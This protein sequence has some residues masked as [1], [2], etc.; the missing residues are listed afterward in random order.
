MANKYVTPAGAGAKD[1][2]SWDNAF[3]ATEFF[4]DIQSGGTLTAGDI[5]YLYGIGGVLTATSALTLLNGVASNIVSFICVSNTTT[6]A[7]AT[8]DDRITWAMGSNRCLYGSYKNAYGIKF[9]TSYASEGIRSLG[10]CNFFKCS[11][12][13]TN[14]YAMYSTNAYDK[15]YECYFF[16][17]GS[18][19][20]AVWGVHCVGCVGS[21][22]NG[23]AF[24]FT[25]TYSFWNMAI[26][27]VNGFYSYVPLLNCIAY[28]CSGKGVD[29]SYPNYSRAVLNCL[30]VN[31]GIG[32]S[33]SETDDVRNCYIDYNN[34]YNCTK[35]YAR[36]TGDEDL[37]LAGAND[38]YL[39]PQF[40]DADN[41]NFAIGANLRSKG[42]PSEFPNLNT[43]SYVD[44]GA[45]QIREVL[46]AVEDV[47]SGV[48]Y[49]ANGTELTGTLTA[50][51]GE[52]SYTF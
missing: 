38:T 25:S 19:K 10:N 18:S 49:G 45:V 39:D 4:T 1:G 43:K 9:T 13:S 15:A 16:T 3:G 33:I 20:I 24:Y 37:T 27:S 32:I 51:G 28:N 42:F 11:L 22:P 21:A 7:I 36:N 30:I 47:E 17:N 14:G 34:I 46:P 23:T 29:L 40:I 41:G 44:I 8:G 52:Y 35:K 5:Y 50:S 26:N 31:C 6:L 12:S 48:Q 2:T